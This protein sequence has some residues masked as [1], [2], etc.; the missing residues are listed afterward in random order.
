MIYKY[1]MKHRGVSIG[2]QPSDFISFDDVNK[3]ETGYWSFV[4]YNRKL[5][6]DEISKY[7]LTFI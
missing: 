6:N 4:Y 2:T 1:G 3:K 7:E 5:S